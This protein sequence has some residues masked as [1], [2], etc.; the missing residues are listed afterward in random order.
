MQDIIQHIRKS[1]S[2][3]YPNSEISGFTRLLIEHVTKL[4]VPA[5]LSDKSKKITGEELLIIDKIIERLQ[6]FEPIQYILGETEFYGLTY[7]VN[8]NVLIPRPETEEL[9]ELIINE[10]N[11]TEN[12][13]VLDIGTGS[14]CIA[15]SLKKHLPQ[16]IVEGWDI[17]GGALE[18]AELNSKKNSVDITLKQ[19]DILSDYHTDRSFDIIVSNP[20]Y[21]LDSEKSEMHTN[22][23]DYE[24]HTALFV[25]DNN[26]LLFYSRIAEV[27]TKLL[28]HGGKLYF[29]INRMKGKETIAMLEDKKFA[30]IQLF[31]DIS[32]ND[33]IVTAEYNSPT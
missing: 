14:G 21:V 8:K 29:E 6:K 9:V 30:N 10:N 15:I 26:P 16:S 13:R 27:A 18:V 23:L 3:F 20:P 25:S 28:S 22:V 17:S 7:L 1:L 33:R 31:K 32:G 4:S 5:F 2:D 11:A 12:C 24:P 19:V